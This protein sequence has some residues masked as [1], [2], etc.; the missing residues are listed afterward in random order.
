MI[1]QIIVWEEC[2]MKCK[3]ILIVAITIVFSI[4]A[5]VLALAT[6][7]Q[8]ATTSDGW[9]YE[10]NTDD[11][12]TILGV[13]D[14]S[15]KALTVPIMLDGKLVTGIGSRAFADMPQLEGVLFH[16][17]VRCFAPDAFD[18]F[19]GKIHA[20]CGAPALTFANQA[21][22]P[23]VDMSAFDLA[24]DVLD[25][26]HW[27]KDL[28]RLEGNRVWVSKAVE[29]VFPTGTRFL[30][31]FENDEVETVRKVASI[32]QMEDGVYL[33][34]VV[35]PAHE[36]LENL[37]FNL[38]EAVLSAVSR[39]SSDTNYVAKKSLTKDFKTDNGLLQVKFDVDL[40]IVPEFDFSLSYDRID[41]FHCVFYYTANVTISGTLGGNLLPSDLIKVSLE[42]ASIFEPIIVDLF[43]T[44]KKASKPQKFEFVYDAKLVI[45]PTIIGSGKFHFEGHDGF[46]FENGMFH[47]EY[48]EPVLK[49]TE[50]SLKG[51]IKVGVEVSAALSIPLHGKFLTL[52]SEAGVKM[53]VLP[54]PSADPSFYCINL[55]FSAYLSAGL[56]L[57]PII[58]RSMS[59]KLLPFEFPI[60][61]YHLEI[62]TTIDEWWKIHLGK[63]CSIDPE[64]IEKVQLITGTNQVYNEI[65][66][67]IGTSVSDSLDYEPIEELE[68]NTFLGWFD[69]PIGGTQYDLTET[70]WEGY[71]DILYAQFSKPAVK[72]TIDYCWNKKK[73][74]VYYRQQGSKLDT[75][76][77]YQRIGY[78]F[79]GWFA[80]GEPWDFS[81][82]TIPETELYIYAIW[83]EDPNY[84]P[85]TENIDAIRNGSNAIQQT[86]YS[87]IVY[88][89]MMST[90]LQGLGLTFEDDNELE[91]LHTTISVTGFNGDGA[92]VPPD[93]VN[94][95]KVKLIDGTAMNKATL[96]SL[97]TPSY[98]L[99]I[100]GM[101]DSPVLS[102]V[103][104]NDGM[105]IIR[106]NCFEN[107]PM[108]CTYTMP[109]TVRKIGAYA[110]FNCGR[111][112][113]AN[114]GDCI[115][116]GKA[117]F[118]NCVS[119]VEVAGTMNVVRQNTFVNCRELTNPPEFVNAVINDYAFAGCSSLESLVF[120]GNT[121]F[122]SDYETFEGCS[123][124]RDITFDGNVNE[125]ALA[126][127]GLDSLETLTISGNCESIYLSDLP[128]LRT[129]LI[130][131]NV[132]G[133]L[134]LSKLPNLTTLSIGGD[135][136]GTLKLNNLPMLTDFIMTGI[137]YPQN[138]KV[139]ITNCH[140]LT[141]LDLSN[142]NCSA[143]CRIFLFGN[144]SLTDVTLPDDLEIIADSMF[145]GCSSIEQI[146][147]PPKVRIVEEYAFAYCSA[148]KQL[149]LNEGLTCLEQRILYHTPGITSLVIPDSVVTF[150]N[151]FTSPDQGGF[152][153]R[154]LCSTNAQAQ[155]Y[156]ST[157]D[158]LA[159]SNTASTKYALCFSSNQQSNSV[160]ELHL[161]NAGDDITAL[162]PDW[163]LPSDT[164][165]S[166]W[167][168]DQECTR[169]YD[170]SRGM[171][172][173]DLCLY[174]GK[175]QASSSFTYR[176]SYLGNELAYCIT[177]YIGSEER[178]VIPEYIGNRPVSG[179]S[180]EAF[181]GTSVRSI[182]LPGSLVDVS[183]N[184]FSN[185]EVLESFY[186]YGEPGGI[187]VVNGVL[188][189]AKG[190]EL[191]RVPPLKTGTLTLPSSVR[192][193]DPQAFHQSMLIEVIFNEGLETIPEKACT[194]MDALERV[195]FPSTLKTVGD[196]A[197]SSCDMLSHITL[198]GEP[199]F[200]QYMFSLVAS[201]QAV[202]PESDTLRTFFSSYL[203]PYNAHNLFWISQKKTVLEQL[204]N[205]GEQIPF[206]SSC[207]A[208]E[209]YVLTGWT[210]GETD[211]EWDFT[212]GVM[213]GESLELH[214]VWSPIWEIDKNGMIVSYNILAGSEAI[215]PNA[216]NEIT[217]TGIKAGV[218][219]AT[220]T[221]ITIPA[222]AETIENGAFTGTPVIVA[223]EGSAAHSFANA[224]G[225]A[226]EKRLYT[227]HFDTNGGSRIEEVALAAG[228]ELVLSEPIRDLCLFT[229]WYEND[230]LFEATV[231]PTR[232]LYL[233]A[234]WSEPDY[235]NPLFSTRND[236]GGVW[237]TGYAGAPATITLPLTINGET[238]L[239]V[240]PGAFRANTVMET[241]TIPDGFPII[242]REAFADSSVRSV[243]FQGADTILEEGVFSRCRLLTELVLPSGLTE[244]PAKTAASAYSLIDITW[245]EALL[246]IG[247]RAFANCRSLN[248][249]LPDTLTSIGISS[250][251]NASSIT[252]SQLPEATG[253]IGEY[254]FA[255]C[256]SITEFI[257][258]ES[259][260]TLPTGLF[261]NCSALE[262]ITLPASLVSL[263]TDAFTGCETL[264]AIHIT[265]GNLYFSSKEGLLLNQDGTTLL[266][267][268][269]GRADEELVV[270]EGITTL[271]EASLSGARFSSIVLPESLQIIGDRAMENCY[272]L[273]ELLIPS[274]VTSIGSKAFAG[275]VQLE[276]IS[277]PEKL[278]TVAIDAFPEDISLMVDSDWLSLAALIP[279][280]EAGVDVTIN[281]VET[282]TSELTYRS[283][284][285]GF[286]ITGYTGGK[287]GVILPSAI[288]G[289]PVLAVDKD[290]LSGLIYCDLPNSITTLMDGALTN[291]PDLRWLYGGEGIVDASRYAVEG[292]AWAKDQYIVSL[293]SV[294][295]AY[296]TSA[297]Q[298][299]LDGQYPIIGDE[300]FRDL[301]T[302][303]YIYM[304]GVTTI[305]DR[306]FAGCT[307]LHILYDTEAV[308]TWGEDL[309]TGTDL[310]RS[311]LILGSHLLNVPADVRDTYSF[312][313][314]TVKVMDS[315]ALNDCQITTLKIVAE[316]CVL[317]TGAA[318][319]NQLLRYVDATSITNLTIEEGALPSQ[320]VVIAVK[321][322]AIWNRATELGY[323]VREEK[324]SLITLNYSSIDVSL[325][326]NKWL[327]ASYNGQSLTEADVIASSS[328]TS[329]FT[330]SVSVNQYE[331][332]G[333]TKYDIHL[334]LTPVNEGTATLTLGNAEGVS[335]YPVTVR[336][337]RM[338]VTNFSGGYE[339]SMAVNEELQLEV[340]NGYGNPIE[341][342][343]CELVCLNGSPILSASSTGL[344]KG[345]H[346]GDGWLH[347]SKE[348]YQTVSLRVTVFAAPTGLTV[349]QTNVE[350]SAGTYL[351]IPITLHGTSFGRIQCTSSNEDVAEAS[352]STYIDSWTITDEGATTNLGINCRNPG[353]TVVT[354][355][356]TEGHTDSIRV[357][358][359]PCLAT[360][361][362]VYPTTVELSPGDTRWIRATVYPSSTTNK[363]L[364]WQSSDESVATV[365]QEGHVLA[366]GFGQATI[367]VSTTD[368][369][370]LT[371]T[372]TVTVDGI[373][374]VGPDTVDGGTETQY[375]AQM[376]DGTPVEVIWSTVNNKSDNFIDRKGILY[377]D[378]TFEQDYLLTICAFSNELG[379]SSQKTVLI[380]SN[381]EFAGYITLPESLTVIEEEAY[382]GTPFFSV[383]CPD[384]LTTIGEGAFRNS[385]ILF[386]I[387]IPA[388]VVSISDTAFEGCSE[389]LCLYVQAGSYAEEYA[390]TK[391]YI[392]DIVSLPE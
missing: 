125:F 111:L 344:L 351:R 302:V 82:K 380:K 325:G 30:A 200:G 37:S 157:L 362:S 80:N 141:Q 148:L 213:P 195:S 69:K 369:S 223:D 340:Q 25:L 147:L 228:D 297:S 295:L 116:V 160:Y 14:S 96:T 175:S 365:D 271:G 211:T 16:V 385:S 134:S 117:A 120:T 162:E 197:F 305:G 91:K 40:K 387:Y 174:M 270:P 138:N 150:N 163:E 115:D 313:D 248:C 220:M 135:L 158:W 161:V 42:E 124:L 136:N 349:E 309:L 261:E 219:D 55:P 318:S 382:A 17:G 198:A 75:P 217:V 224:N 76:F 64:Q 233:V 167:Y 377:P 9:L 172:G 206:Y 303:W 191:L 266:V 164:C 360:S 283:F 215:V 2:L 366:N 335:V 72:V 83:E 383:R 359:T 242:G 47:R 192:T 173:K 346:K 155:Q 236:E 67:R 86:H 252:I 65:W 234:S 3:W 240:D 95:I 144:K 149:V 225:Y 372:C 238:V 28:I 331:Y 84:N 1:F 354:L 94:A 210:I 156:V 269:S 26:N 212:T 8:E 48:D 348:G 329:I 71:P 107:N 127:E 324:P 251:E 358:V 304:Q 39:D 381:W 97:A 277:L 361:V 246:S 282:P 296:Q 280:I 73:P 142:V 15:A 131:G 289:K 275:C 231:M 36:V 139:E 99:A 294:L 137:I 108:L 123:S 102:Y 62:P 126:N 152:V 301:N 31:Y 10:I 317:K 244:I 177:G 153:L 180:A 178:V 171:L 34:C 118:A 292:T 130:D 284:G 60:E 330:V 112:I 44:P 199:E 101:K 268:P 159:F 339:C 267:C 165:F 262:S 51:E 121:Y 185:M 41:Y 52:S 24:D 81:N 310:K 186:L 169:R 56:N 74:E 19:N 133:T 371:A 326:S 245:P 249:E 92:L 363:T 114:V 93:R 259:I 343:T 230:L 323:E 370:N 87:N 201:I 90:G 221:R 100:M 319:N 187:N 347:I 59:Y 307:N 23:S 281:P 66:A 243:T 110:F 391:G 276:Q 321:D 341:G 32:S 373:I 18:G 263:G 256:D 109:S 29:S 58:F 368:G 328:D 257:L 279:A 35:V 255:S 384:G 188:Y 254:A 181:S 204:I 43:D 390:T 105:A 89:D 193:I 129:V 334:T 63:F 46:V 336:D 392:V 140:Q 85:F 379:K 154:L 378:P 312:G 57:N 272:Y 316:N 315:G 327:S 103:H 386:D 333:V 306:A 264:S 5:P 332:N 338:Y 237:I 38:D 364:Y 278:D 308:T 320:T 202:G 293:G 209:G 145:Y 183:G 78:R 241:V 239:G 218:F 27:G 77:P 299:D 286:I 208:P 337:D 11:T 253:T 104:L 311:Y 216:V 7:T 151:P 342:Y 355:T 194:T 298:I 22:I 106:D 322:S 258:P 88:S 389:Y 45:K 113:S 314:D 128:N 290:A 196:G 166:G 265:E 374:I 119:L 356:T 146:T 168:L 122:A 170:L 367:T 300:A 6:E 247:D 345:L 143:D 12:L 376:Q 274:K 13:E 68:E 54:T 375:T 4:A 232:D 250:F 235:Y 287:T 288:D 229:G 179:I 353:E 357:V 70:V 49:V 184:A 214:A 227:V 226:F 273:T 222:C 190:D 285:E 132:N 207:T 189:T 203:I 260:E 50:A 33:N 98:C 350:A 20:Y 176:D 79:V 182:T 291:C 205:Q 21:N 61:T 388:S 352:V 53:K